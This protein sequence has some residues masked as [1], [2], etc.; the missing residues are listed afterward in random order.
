[1]QSVCENRQVLN[2]GVKQLSFKGKYAKTEKGNLY[3]H[4]NSA[5]KIGGTMAASEL[6]L[7]GLSLLGGKH[8]K[9]IT[10]TNAVLAAVLHLGVASFIDKKRNEKTK[11]FTDCFN[12]Y[13]FEKTLPVYNDLAFSE[14]GNLYYKTK[15]GAEFGGWLGTGIGVLTCITSLIQKRASVPEAILSIGVGALGGWMLGR[16]SDNVANKEMRKVI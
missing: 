7:G 6:V 3:Y 16:L 10:I 8:N 9:A 11:E 15:T 1:M 2:L 13:G 5:M 4:T 14:R 12:A